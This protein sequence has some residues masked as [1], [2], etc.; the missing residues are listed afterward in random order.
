MCVCV[1]VR[2]RERERERCVWCYL[3]QKTCRY[4]LIYDVFVVVFILN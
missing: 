4:V 1:C 2:E 3:H